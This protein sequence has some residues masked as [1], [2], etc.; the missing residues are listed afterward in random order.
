MVLAIFKKSKIWIIVEKI[1][2]QFDQLSDRMLDFVVDFG[3]ILGHS[4]SQ[5]LLQ[6]AILFVLLFCQCGHFG[7][8]LFSELFRVK[9]FSELFS[10]ERL[11]GSRFFRSERILL[12]PKRS[13][14][15]VEIKVLTSSRKRAVLGVLIVS[16][17]SRFRC[18]LRGFT[19]SF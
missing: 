13:Y 3:K 8:E 1:F 2:Q 10:S 12:W 4:A 9:L 18:F 19:K 7:S 16:K 5:A 11:F 15:I 17:I 14:N 6:S